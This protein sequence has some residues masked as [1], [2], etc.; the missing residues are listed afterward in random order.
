M[1]DDEDNQLLAN[2]FQGNSSASDGQNT[3]PSNPSILQYPSPIDKLDETTEL[4][5][6]GH[7]TK[8]GLS[9]LKQFQLEAIRAV[10]KNKDVIIIQKTG[11]GKSLCYQLPSLFDKKKTTVV[12]CPTISL[13]NSQLENLVEYNITAV[14]A[15]PNFQMDTLFLNEEALPALIYTTPEYFLNKLKYRLSADK[16]K[17]IV[18]DEVHKVFDR[19]ENFRAS[20][21]TLSELHKEFPLVPVMALTATLDEEQLRSLC[22]S[23]LDNPVLIRA[24]VNRENIKLNICKYKPK[25]ALKGNTSL[26]WMDVA[27]EIHNIIGEEYAIVYMDFKKDVE[28]MVTC[29]KDSGVEYV[30][31]YHGGLPLQEK[32]KVDTAFRNKEFQILIATESYEVGTHSPHVHTVFRIGCMRNVGVVIQE[33][34]R[35]GRSGEQSDGFLFF[36]E[37]KDDQR[38]TYWTMNC[39]SNET[40]VIKKKY[41]ETYSSIYGI[42]NGTCLRKSLLRSYE[43]SNS[44]QECPSGDCCSSCDLRTPVDFDARHCHSIIKGN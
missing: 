27:K 5:W 38:L 32:N 25:K 22:S 8:F 18:I 43:N 14:A 36:N 37:H 30:R 2:Q 44:L 20:Y 40:A 26:V 15:G 31:A 13:I 10:E 34:G 29:L 23:Y 7:L 4:L 41:Q 42:Y 24:S 21:D 3:I 28:L 9:S 33:F 6:N 12:I 39:N 11:S 16:L 17:L 1:S 19:H 35:A